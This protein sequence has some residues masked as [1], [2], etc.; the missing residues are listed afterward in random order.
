MKA[1]FTEIYMPVHERFEV[2]LAA[3]YDHYSGFGGTANPKVSFKWQPLDSLAFRG[4]YSTGFKAPEFSKLY[5]GTTATQNT[6]LD[7][8]DPEKCP[9]GVVN[10]AVP[11]CES[12]RPDILVGGKEDL[13]PEEARQKSLGLVFA[14]VGWFN[15][16]VDW[17]EIERINTIR[18]GPDLDTL[19]DNYDLFRDNWIRDATGEVVLIDRRFVN[20]GG[21]LM[22]GVEVDANFTG[23]M[24][25][26]NYRLNFN[27]S[28]LDN[29][30]D[31]LLE[32]MPY[33]DN[34]VGQYLRYWSLPIKWKHT[35]GFSWAK[36]D[37]AHSLTQVYRHG[38][39]DEEPTSVSSGHY[40][41]S[42]WNPDVSRY[43][44]Y[45]YSV[46]YTGF[47]KL[48]L[49]LGVKNL[50]DR[51]PPF[52]AHKNDWAS[53]AGWEPRIADPRGRAYSLLAEYRF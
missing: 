32:F 11:G 6:A 28:Y 18:T 42:D 39:K 36:G 34:Q 47:D 12:I 33:T 31:K 43:I 22:S 50:T 13:E 7:V 16:S 17:W 15:M 38:Y 44:T 48:R 46:T 49:V 14:P 41:P 9:G 24:A 52:T 21:S 19:R 10:D 35:V 1:V 37:W 51:D 8:A 26:G 4:A 5:S 45:N 40:I 2:T 30:Q 23:E 29:Y 27:G 20:S 25:G 3:R 53:G